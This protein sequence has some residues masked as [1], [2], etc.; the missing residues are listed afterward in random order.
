[1]SAN[2]RT[3]LLQDSSTAS[4]TGEQSPEN[5]FRE[6]SI[7]SSPSPHQSEN[8]PSHDG[9]AKPPGNVNEYGSNG[10]Q[11]SSIQVKTI[12]VYPTRWYILIVFAL[13]GFL[14]GGMVD[15]WPVIAE[16]AVRKVEKVH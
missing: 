8:S 9:P 11:H 15:S 6:P 7:I 13:L 12:K 3:P 16:S 4:A 1:M 2:E 5:S 10:S 14:Q